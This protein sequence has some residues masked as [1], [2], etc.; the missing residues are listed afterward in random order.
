MPNH[1]L[2]SQHSQHNVDES[3]DESMDAEA[4]SQGSVEANCEPHQ[5]G[6]AHRFKT[7]H[8]D[9]SAD[10]NAITPWIAQ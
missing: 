2:D 5:A 8:S 7:T 6:L 1:L 3:V 9:E 4:L 10:N